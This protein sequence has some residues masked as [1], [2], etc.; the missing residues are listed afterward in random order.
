MDN[1]HKIDFVVNGTG[2]K[3]FDLTLYSA[4]H[5]L[6]TKFPGLNCELTEHGIHVCGE[7]N[8]YWFEKYNRA[9]LELED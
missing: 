2:S 6:C 8:D 1:L 7:L 4:A 9:Q 5:K 3:L